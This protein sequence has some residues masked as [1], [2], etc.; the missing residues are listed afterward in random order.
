M[1][2]SSNI[3][4]SPPGVPSNL[5]NVTDLPTNI[6]EKMDFKPG[7]FTLAVLMILG[8]VIANMVVIVTILTHKHLRSQPSK[9][10]LLNM[11]TSL[12]IKGI[13]L[14]SREH[15][16]KT[17]LPDWSNISGLCVPLDIIH[18]LKIY[19]VPIATLLVVVERLVCLIKSPS[20]HSGFGARLA[21]LLMILG[22]VVALVYTLVNILVVGQIKHRI[23]NSYP[24]CYIHFTQ[25]AIYMFL[26]TFIILGLCILGVLI[27]IVCVYFRRA[28]TP[29]QRHNIVV[30]T[31]VPTSIYVTLK[32]FT[33]GLYFIYYTWRVG[34]QVLIVTFN[35]YFVYL[36]VVPL[37][38]L[39][40]SRELRQAAKQLMCPWCPKSES[41][42]ENIILN[43]E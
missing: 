32:L 10:L 31:L 28:T 16:S 7:W 30:A 24:Q 3:S 18:T 17:G 5:S 13:L 2:L 42:D 22:W 27:A 21:I 36:I 39:F 12:L 9:W 6:V 41:Q 38:W 11:V 33:Y 35:V 43:D 4:V 23:F 20:H 29:N 8:C 15:L 1:A 40:A 37:G 14:V 26:I 25:T 19:V 34:A